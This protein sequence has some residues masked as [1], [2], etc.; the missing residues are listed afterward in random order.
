[1]RVPYYQVDAFA[2]RAFA[3]NPAG[4]CLLPHWLPDATLQ[5]IALDNNLSETAFLVRAGAGYELR[6]FTP[7]AEIDLC[8]HATLASGAVLFR[9]YHPEERNLRFSTRYAGVLEVRREDPLLLIDLPAWPPAPCPAPP[10][11]AEI[12][13]APPRALLGAR[14]YLAVYDDERQIRALAPDFRRMK[15]EIDRDVIVTAP[16]A[17]VDFVSRY[18]A[19][20]YGVDEDPVTGSAHCIATPYW[21]QRLGRTRL[22]ARQLSRR[23]GELQ[24]ELRGERVLLGGQAVLVVDGHWHVPD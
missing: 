1:M 10:A 13:G 7:A 23:G 18:F 16:G 12:L 22:R 3:G 17:E 8:G 2:E 14:D 11:L 9:R 24:C 19:P 20:L 21:A 4:V 6:W 5:G 15:R